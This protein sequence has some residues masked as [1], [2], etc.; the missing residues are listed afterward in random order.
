MNYSALRLPS[1]VLATT[2]LISL[3]SASSGSAQVITKMPPQRPSAAIPQKGSAVLAHGPMGPTSQAGETRKVHGSAMSSVR[4]PTTH[5][6]TRE[7]TTRTVRG[8]TVRTTG[9]TTVASHGQWVWRSGRRVWQSY[10][11]TGAGYAYEPVATGAVYGGTD[12]VARHSCWW[13]RHYDPAD[14]PRWCPRYYG[15]TYGYSYG[16]SAPSYGYSAPAYSYGYR[17]GAIRT[18]S[19]RVTST[20]VANVSTARFTSRTHGFTQGGAH[21]AVTRP[22]EMGAH[23]RSHAEAGAQVRSASKGGA[24]VRTRT[25]P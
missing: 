17:Y 7:T 20:R 14:L 5:V 10:G 18:A 3:A 15:T 23:V 2:A 1:L 4:Q 21:V 19:T 25:S 24:H 11:F 8:T 12:G 22:A 9:G 16:N 13:Y 6:A